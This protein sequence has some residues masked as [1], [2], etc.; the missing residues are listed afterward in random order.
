[1]TV[2]GARQE[3]RHELE[4]A[5]AKIDRLRDVPGSAE[6]QQEIRHYRFVAQERL[7][8]QLAEMDES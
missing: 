1:M 5:I 8:S 3:A 4:K 2:P 6:W 7:E